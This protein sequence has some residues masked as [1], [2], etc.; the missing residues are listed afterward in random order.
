MNAIRL[1][2]GFDSSLIIFLTNL[3][4]SC[5][6]NVGVALIGFAIVMIDIL[7]VYKSFGDLRIKSLK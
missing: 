1:G 2:S 7:P 6:R 3:I 5:P 4:A